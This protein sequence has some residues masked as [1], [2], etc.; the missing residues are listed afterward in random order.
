MF[1]LTEIVLKFTLE[2][3]FLEPFRVPSFWRQE[4]ML[5]GLEGGRGRGGFA[6]DEGGVENAVAMGVKGELG[7]QSMGVWLS[8]LESLRRRISLSVGSSLTFAFIGKLT[9]EVVDR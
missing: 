5:T 7:R 9:V 1:R 6:K 3:A 4:I 8:S 2:S